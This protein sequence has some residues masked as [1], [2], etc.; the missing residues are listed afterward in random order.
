MLLIRFPVE[1]YNFNA[2][3]VKRHSIAPAA[4]TEIQRV[5]WSDAH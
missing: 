5:V 3:H 1:V 2:T 4:Q